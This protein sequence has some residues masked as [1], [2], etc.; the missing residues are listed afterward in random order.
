MPGSCDERELF[1][2]LCASVSLSER[3]FSAA[4]SSLLRFHDGVVELDGC[5]VFST[6]TSKQGGHALSPSGGFSFKILNVLFFVCVCFLVL[7]WIFIVHVKLK[8]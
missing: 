7:L 5:A 8:M 2:Y 4:H 3:L 1:N 6:L